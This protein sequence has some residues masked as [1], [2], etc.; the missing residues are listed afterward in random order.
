MFA[1]AK[2]EESWEKRRE[3]EKSEITRLAKTQAPQI[4]AEQP[5]ILHAYTAKHATDVSAYEFRCERWGDFLALFMGRIQNEWGQRNGEHFMEDRMIREIVSVNLAICRDISLRHGRESDLLGTVSFTRKAEGKIIIL[6]LDAEE[7]GTWRLQM[8]NE[9]FGMTG[10]SG[11]VIAFHSHE[12]A[13][14]QAVDDR[15]IFT[16]LDGTLFVPVG[17]GQE[18]YNA[19]LAAI[20][21]GWEK[22]GAA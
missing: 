12:G 22:V 8:K 11:P 7:T 10:Y 16:G 14:R 13:A 1:R 18:V 15:I 17:R 2:E 5:S 6:P 21:R 19:I 3:K 20:G 9:N 4:L